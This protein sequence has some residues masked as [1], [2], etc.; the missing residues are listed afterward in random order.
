MVA[1]YEPATGKYYYYTT[2]QIN[3]TRVVTDDVGNI[4]YAAA[5]DPYGGILKT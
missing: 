5:H 1:E 4:V 2:D 3:S